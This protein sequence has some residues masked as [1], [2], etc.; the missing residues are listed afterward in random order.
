MTTEPLVALRTYVA[1]VRHYLENAGEFLRKGEVEK[2][3]EFLWGSMAAV[4][5]AVA[6]SR[7]RELRHHRGIW[8]YAREMAKQGENERFFDAFREANSLHSNFYEAALTPAD[9]ELVA[10][11][12]REAIAWAI[13]LIP[14][15][16][17][18]EANEE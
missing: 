10:P 16:A 7:G 2:C 13:G 14:E 3:S 11:R 9:V 17:L 18:Q 5:K 15:E 8:E 1:N 6:I 4:V 12:I